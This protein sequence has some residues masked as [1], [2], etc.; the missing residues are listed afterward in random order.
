MSDQKL[1]IKK[2]INLPADTAP[3]TPEDGDI[4][5]D[6]SATK[7]KFRENGNWTQIGTGGGDVSS[8]TASSVDSEI[9]LFS[10]TAGKT[11]KRA[12]GTGLATVT[13]GVLG[14]V[15]APSGAVVGT[16]DTQTLTNK[17]LTSPVINSPTGITKGDVGLGNVDNTSDATKN[18]ASVTLTNKTLTSPVINSPTGIVKGDVGLGNVDNTSDATKNAAS[19]TLTNKTIDNTNT[20]SIKDTN[21]TIQDD[22]DTTKQAKFQASGI[23]TGTTRTYVL[24]DISDTLVTLTATQTLTN[25]TLTSPAITTPT[26]IIKGDVGLGN[27]DNT[28]DAT[29]N[30]A[31]VTLTNKTIDNTNSVT[32]KDTNFTVQDDGDTTKQ[33]KIQA[34]GI[35]TGTTR[36]MT[37]PDADFTAVG[38]T[39]SQTLTNKTL[40]TPTVADFT[41]A[42]HNHNNAAGGGQISLTAGVTG[43][44]PIANGGTNANT[45]NAG[46]NNLLPSQATNGGKVLGTDGTN[47]SWVSGTGQ[48]LRTHD[49]TSSGTLTL[50][51][52]VTNIEVLIG[53]GGG[54]GGGSGA[55]SAVAGSGGAG[56]SGVVPQTQR[57][58]AV[59]SDVLTI[60]I[61]AGGTGGNAGTVGNAGSVGGGGGASSVTGTGVD[62][63]SPGGGGGDRSTGGSPTVPGAATTSLAESVNGATASTSGAGNTTGSASGVGQSAGKTVYV[64]TSP[65][66]GGDAAVGG[67]NRGG[68]GGGGGSGFAAGG[69]G[70]NGSIAGNST[71]STVGVAAAANSSAG[72]GGGAGNISNVAGK[73]GGNGGSG[74]IRITYW[75]S[76]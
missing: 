8:N 42:V 13:S 24:P 1:K 57:S 12:T 7:F 53:G 58:K 43:I 34:S 25:K 19:V 56:G 76:L 59:G 36:T 54:G 66:A 27:V 71:S 32:V 37:V 5:Y 55:N 51:A 44:L 22:G 74:F 47:T 11:I 67:T 60:T 15:T 61:G 31:S 39:T 14:T 45:A 20:V 23:T 9:A 29:K 64:A 52:D 17:T 49:F 41:N 33:F 50:E 75:S 70:G 3:S 68:P 10:G 62:I 2:G 21:F 65:A 26:G 73:A 18:A 6:S 4:Y 72:G 38:T 28:S 46:L 69:K 48:T 35:T 16:T 63:Y 30:A 40:T